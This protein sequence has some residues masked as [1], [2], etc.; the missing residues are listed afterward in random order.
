V[1]YLAAMLQFKNVILF[2]ALFLFAS[3]SSVHAFE[4]EIFESTKAVGE[5]LKSQCP[6]DHCAVIG[7]GRSPTPFIAYLQESTGNDHYAINLPLSRFRYDV[8][9]YP[10]LSKRG[11][12]YLFK[13]FDLYLSQLDRAQ[14]KEVLVVDY[15]QTGVSLIAARRHIRT[16]FNRVN[17]EQKSRKEDQVHVSSC[18]VISSGQLDEGVHPD[19]MHRIILPQRSALSQSLMKQVFD[20]SSQF[21]PFYIEYV[22]SSSDIKRLSPRREYVKL[23]REI[24]RF[25]QQDRHKSISE[26]SPSQSLFLVEEYRKLSVP[27]ILRLQDQQEALRA[28]NYIQWYSAE[29]LSAYFIGVFSR[30][31]TLGVVPYA[32]SRL[33]L[34]YEKLRPPRGQFFDLVFGN[35]KDAVIES[36]LGNLF[37]Q[38]KL[39]LKKY[40][41]FSRAAAVDQEILADLV[42]SALANKKVHLL[43]KSLF[44]N[45]FQMYKFSEKQK[46]ETYAFVINRALISDNQ[47]V[48]KLGRHFYRGFDSYA[49]ANIFM[50][51]DSSAKNKLMTGRD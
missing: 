25:L 34:S 24:R 46:I 7:V 36:L 26:P 42:D 38:S 5:Y 1:I 18:A 40:K 44:K 11:M 3:S 33:V 13:H 45:M 10:Q 50:R 41:K 15:A 6:P 39:V 14:L 21:D 28:T 19:L 17:S 35:Q 16:Y 47:A 23:R 2:F 27:K 48:V 32:V 49:K 9:W 8:K 31:D 30:P 37:L 29:D 12:R 51:L 22:K 4:L 43:D 20:L